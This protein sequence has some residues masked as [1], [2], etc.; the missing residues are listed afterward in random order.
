MKMDEEEED[1]R[2]HA[3]LFLGPDSESPLPA[4]SFWGIRQQRGTGLSTRRPRPP[5]R[6]LGEAAQRGGSSDARG[7]R[8]AGL[9]SSLPPSSPVSSV[10]TQPA[11]LSHKALRDAGSGVLGLGFALPAA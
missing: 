7:S 10:V 9:S 5:A 8:S 6:P 11:R 3:F 2:Q 4:D 1:P